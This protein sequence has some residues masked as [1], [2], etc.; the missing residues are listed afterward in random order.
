MKKIIFVLIGVVLVIGLV[1]CISGERVVDSGAGSTAGLFYAEDKERGVIC[2]SMTGRSG[3]DCVWYAN[4][5][6]E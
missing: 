4:P 2:Y 3:V 5:C 1:G 6:G